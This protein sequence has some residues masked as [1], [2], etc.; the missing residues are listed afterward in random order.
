ML[1]NSFQ[2]ALQTLLRWVCCLTSW[3]QFSSWLYRLV[4]KHIWIGSLFY[5]LRDCL[6]PSSSFGHLYTAT[7]SYWSPGLGLFKAQCLCSLLFIQKLAQYAYVYMLSC[8]RLC[9]P[10]DCSPPG[11]SVHGILQGGILQW[12]AIPFSRR[13]SQLRDWTRVSCIADRFFTI[14]TT[15]KA[16][17]AQ[18]WWPKSLF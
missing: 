2:F 16:Q 15:R 8:V 6:L 3:W 11:S 5:G 13:S 12:V 18:C 7:P 9:D 4:C 10:M 1:F 14:C 17:L